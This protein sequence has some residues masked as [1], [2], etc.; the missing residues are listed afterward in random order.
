MLTRVMKKATAVTDEVK[1]QVRDRTRSVKKS[2]IE[3]DR[4]ARNKTEKGQQKLKEGYKKLLESYSSGGRTSE[5]SGAGN[6]PRETSPRP[7][8]WPGYCRTPSTSWR[9]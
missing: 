8:R 9:L 4:A 1:T 5:T 6:R 2:V 7:R 3:I